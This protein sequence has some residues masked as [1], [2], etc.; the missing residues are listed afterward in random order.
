M[1]LQRIFILFFSIFLLVGCSTEDYMPGNA[2]LYTGDPDYPDSAVKEQLYVS[3][4]GT[5]ADFQIITDNASTVQLSDG[6]V[7]VNGPVFIETAS[8]A[9]PVRAAELIV[10]Q[11]GTVSGKSMLPDFNIGMWKELVWQKMSS[12]VPMVVLKG[13]Q[14]L[15][16]ESEYCIQDGN[17]NRL[18]IISE[19]IY[20]LYKIDLSLNALMAC[21]PNTPVSLNVDRVPIPQFQLYYIFDP[22]DPSFFLTLNT[23]NFEKLEKWAA[24]AGSDSAQSGSGSTQSGG[25]DGSG[26]KVSK[27]NAKSKLS[28]IGLLD[29]LNGFGIG[30][31]SN[32]LLPFRMDYTNLLEPA[33]GVHYSFGTHIWLKAAIGIQKYGLPF[34]LDGNIGLNLNP[35]DS[36]SVNLGVAGIKLRMGLNGK[37]FFDIASYIGKNTKPGAE[38][39]KKIKTLQILSSIIQMQELAGA[40]VVC[41]ITDKPTL[42][43]S[44]YAGNTNVTVDFSKL[45]SIAAF[46]G[47]TEKLQNAVNSLLEPPVVMQHRFAGFLQWDSGNK[48]FN[49]YFGYKSI[50]KVRL[51]QMLGPLASFADTDMQL[52]SSSSLMDAEVML[53]IGNRTGFRMYGK[54]LSGFNL[55]KGISLNG[56][57]EIDLTVRSLSDFSFSAQGSFGLKLFS[58]G[59]DLTGSILVSSRKVALSGRM[60][61]KLGSYGSLSGALSGSY[62]PATDNW[63]I[64]GSGTFH[65]FGYRI[66]NA[67]IRAVNGGL[68]VRGEVEVPNLSTISVSGKINF[69]TGEVA[70][71][72]AA[73]ITIKGYKL[74][75]ATIT[76]G[77]RGLEFSGTLSVPNLTDVVISGKVSADG[78]FSV[79]S[80]A[81]I[82][83][84]GYRIAD[85]ILELSNDGLTVKGS[86]EIPNVS[87]IH[88]EGSVTSSGGIDISGR[89]NITIGG[90]K[91]ANADFSLNKSGFSLSAHVNLFGFMSMDL[92]GRVS[93]GG[94]VNIRGKWS[95]DSGEIGFWAGWVRG[96]ASITAKL[97]SSGFSFTGSIKVSY[98]LRIYEDS[99]TITAGIIADSR[100]IGFKY[101]FPLIGKKTIWVKKNKNL[102]RDGFVLPQPDGVRVFAVNPY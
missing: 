100:G 21:I 74:A 89:A 70:L 85:A 69:R 81:S 2:K 4:G 72:G 102:V 10:R 73:D 23:A 79:A 18:P 57:A 61:I 80:K 6:S 38:P 93:S 30:L 15:D 86:L 95:V 17:T 84:L 98:S 56:G 36:G 52:G 45:G 75:G 59:A 14:M 87:S 49:W 19:R 29:S 96:E 3:T 64:R 94:Y 65:L 13:S 50:F 5:V 7:A 91:L 8:N 46:K 40:S 58:V 42:Y 34:T 53:Q 26:S 77:T 60:K 39:S 24:P 66:A 48:D 20:I 83:L 62:T 27:D 12:L 82:K 31:S 43:F 44:T 71:T 41:E 97:G 25:S 68:W 1:N 47:G 33:L 16:P 54:L 88:V 51:K 99:F 90:Q 101:K 37:L 92:Y 11:D 76:L 22:N 35:S 55:M 32:G 63:N 78:Q 28:G 67:S 9:T